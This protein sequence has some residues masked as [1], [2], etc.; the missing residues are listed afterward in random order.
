VIPGS[1]VIRMPEAPPAQIWRQSLRTRDGRPFSIRP[2]GA[3]DAQ[4]DR[5]FLMRLSEDSRYKRMMGVCRDPSPELID[6]FVHVDRHGS[7]AFVAVVGAGTA[8][9]IIGAARYAAPA[10][11]QDAE[12]AI[13]VADEWQSRGVGSALL[14][15]LLEYA[16]S[17]G[18]RRLQGVVLANN[19]RMLQFARKHAFLL[20][21]VPGEYTLVEIT[22]DL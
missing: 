16:R 11:S 17:Q 8:E 7:M 3:Q 18:L 10:G 9:S 6:R 20:R 4:R 5:D 14:Q 1:A 2:I 12:F 19:G 15:A 13:A 22:R 21:P